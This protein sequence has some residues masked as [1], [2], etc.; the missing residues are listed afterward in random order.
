MRAIRY[1]PSPPARLMDGHIE[2]GNAGA[3]PC[4]GSHGRIS[5]A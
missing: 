2:H 1:G 5:R 4:E 3:V